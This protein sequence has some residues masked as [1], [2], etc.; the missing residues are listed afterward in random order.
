MQ[1]A[2][3]H[4]GFQHW[5]PFV[6]DGVGVGG[7]LVPLALLVSLCLVRCCFSHLVS[8]TQF[9]ELL[10]QTWFPGRLTACCWFSP[11]LPVAHT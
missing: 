10:P 3:F 9:G 1:F 11:T 6:L 5:L 7:V 8:G 2:E 4:T